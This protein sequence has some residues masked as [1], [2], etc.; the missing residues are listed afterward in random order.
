MRSRITVA[1]LVTVLAATPARAD[2][3]KA[4]ALKATEALPKI[5]GLVVKKTR[6]RSASAAML[7]APPTWQGQ[8][9]PII[10]D[11]DIVAAQR[12]LF[13]TCAR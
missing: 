10:V 9:R 6:T 8:T 5:T 13:H 7:K 3:S 12:K 1:A 2:D 4:C 11:V